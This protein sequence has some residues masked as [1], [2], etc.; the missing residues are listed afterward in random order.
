MWYLTGI[1]TIFDEARGQKIPR[2]GTP[3]GYLQK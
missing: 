1:K 2:D 3:S